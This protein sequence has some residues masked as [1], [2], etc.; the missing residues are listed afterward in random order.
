MK[1]WLEARAAREALEAAWKNSG[2]RNLQERMVSIFYHTV[3]RVR[4]AC[5]GMQ[6]LWRGY[7]SRWLF[8]FP[9]KHA[10]Q[11]CRTRITVW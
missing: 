6:E 11:A 3:M 5:A 2:L 8:F 9:H 7:R 4:H 1:R 10:V